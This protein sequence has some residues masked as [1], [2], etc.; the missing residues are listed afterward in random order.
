MKGN[1]NKE[2]NYELFETTNGNELL[3]LNKNEWY[4]LLS[5]N[6]GDIIV[7]S[8]SDHDKKKTL[9][10]GRFFLA[11]FADDPEFN[12]L[13]HLFMAKGSH[14]TEM[15]LPNGLPTKSDRQKKLIRVKDRLAKSKVNEHVEA[16]EGSGQEKH[17]TGKAEQLHTKTKKELY[18]KAKNEHIEGRSTMNKQELVQHLQD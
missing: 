8:D 16:T 18:R 6:K 9:Q 12:D 1:V 5:G 15:I 3:V 4:A 13:P 14:Y 2:G 7:R 10:K 11:N 17:Y